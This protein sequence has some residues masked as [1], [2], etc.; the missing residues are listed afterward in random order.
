MNSYLQQYVRHTSL[1][2]DGL[3]FNE[4]VLLRKVKKFINEDLKSDVIDA[5]YYHIHTIAKLLQDDGKTF[6]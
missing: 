5:E 3:K 4:S 2:I 1:R 6:K